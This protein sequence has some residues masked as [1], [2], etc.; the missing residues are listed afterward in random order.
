MISVWACL[1]EPGRCDV[2]EQTG[3]LRKLHCSAEVV[4]LPVE[5]FTAGS[6]TRGSISGGV[7]REDKNK[8][9]DMEWVGL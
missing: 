9:V 3:R 7:Q 1:E 6:G 5:R 8:C 4:G 2:T